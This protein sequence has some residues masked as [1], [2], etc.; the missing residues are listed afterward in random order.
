M[1]IGAIRSVFEFWRPILDM[2]PN[3]LTTDMARKTFVTFGVKLHRSGIKSNSSHRNK[4]KVNL[5]RAILIQPTRSCAFKIPAEHL[6]EVTHHQSPAQFQVYV[7]NSAWRDRITTRDPIRKPKR[8][9][10]A[11]ARSGQAD[12]IQRTIS[13][14]IFADNKIF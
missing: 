11:R 1:G 13:N 4:K 8:T 3:P 10:P 14:R 5:F 6:M 12:T 9:P 7:V 2:G